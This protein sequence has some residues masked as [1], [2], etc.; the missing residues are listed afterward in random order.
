MTAARRSAAVALVALVLSIVPSAARAQ[1]ISIDQGVQAAGLWCFPL[2]TEPKTYVYLPSASRL[3]TDASGRP[4]F[5]FVRYITSAAASGGGQESVTTA[6]GGGILHFLVLIET[7]DSTVADALKV[8][9][10]K[11]KDND[12]TLRGPIVFAE[13]RYSLVSS[14]LIKPDAPPER[15]LLATGRAPVLEG[16][17][18]AFSFDLSPDQATLLR[19]SLQMRTPD[20]SI[21]FDMT[22]TG[23]NEAYD[24]D[25]T[26]DWSE[27]RHTQSFSAGGSVLLR[28]RRHRGWLRRHAAQQRDQASVERDR[29][30]DGRPPQHRLLEA[31]R[32]DVQAC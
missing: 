31:P 32:T 29:R 12:V 3:A 11:V 14:V 6:G 16:N 10:E 30:G 5:S 4:Q 24:A 1:Q 17:R 22:F 23:L 20:V 7:P 26:I 9:R 25:M 19:Q 27:I 13:G 28:R 18:L 21:V 15:K 2:V 8:L